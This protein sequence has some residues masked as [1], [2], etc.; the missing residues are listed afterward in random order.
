LL[1]LTSSNKTK[2]NVVMKTSH[3]YVDTTYFDIFFRKTYLLQVGLAKRK[4]NLDER[5]Y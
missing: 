4:L 3:P 5:F 2:V 1:T